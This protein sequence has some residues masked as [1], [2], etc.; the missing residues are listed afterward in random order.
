MGF[1]GAAWQRRTKGASFCHVDRMR[2]VVKSSPWRTSGSQ[3]WTGARPTFKARAIV[4]KA[5][6]RGWKSNPSC[7]CV[8]KQAFS[9]VAKSSREAAVAWVR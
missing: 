2:P 9:I 1:T 8:V 4:R 3:A 7:H 6:G 5:A